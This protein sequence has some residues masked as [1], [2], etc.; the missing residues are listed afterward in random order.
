MCLH[1]V[2]YLTI[3]SSIILLI[4]IESVTTSKPHRLEISATETVFVQMKGF[5]WKNNGKKAS[6]CDWIEAA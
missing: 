5:G 1:I 2:L 6:K 4:F 3:K